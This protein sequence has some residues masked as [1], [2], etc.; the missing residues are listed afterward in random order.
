MFN[1]FR[2]NL[3]PLIIS[4]LILIGSIILA[5]IISFFI[6][7]NIKLISKKL[8]KSD[9]N[10]HITR[11]KLI[12]RILVFIIYFVGLAAILYQFE[13]LKKIG[14]VMFA[15]AS[16]IGIIFGISAQASLGNIIAGVLISFTQPVRLD[17][18]IEVEKQKGIVEDIG[19]I[20]TRI[21]TWDNKRLFIPNRQFFDNKIINYSIIDPV[22]LVRLQFD[23]KNIGA[24][25]FDNYQNKIIKEIKSIKDLELK[26]GPE[27]KIIDFDD[28][29]I[30]IEIWLWLKEKKI[31]DNLELSIKKRIFYLLNKK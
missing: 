9:I 25:E 5:Q 12:R 28:T 15:S 26:V 19:L 29:K 23:L 16:V 13:P 2:N 18:F 24:E 22:N 27:I 8:K 14:T 11:L 17:D 31:D 1:Y 20:Y 3:S 30:K 10:K 21:R 7:S 6:N 4:G